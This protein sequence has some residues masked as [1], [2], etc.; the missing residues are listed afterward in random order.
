[1]TPEDTDDPTEPN[2]YRQ[3]VASAK[4]TA[5]GA[6]DAIADTPGPIGNPIANPLAQG[7]WVCTAADDWIAELHSHLSGVNPAFSDAVTTLQSAYDAESE[8]V[9]AGDPHG[10]AW[11]SFWQMV[12]LNTY[13]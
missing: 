7:G 11:N 1:M 3:T 8:R 4:T 9:P 12:Q 5:V 6:R 2:F 13:Y 10:L